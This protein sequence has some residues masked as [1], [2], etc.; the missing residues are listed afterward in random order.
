MFDF[1]VRSEAA[2]K[3]AVDQLPEIDVLNGDEAEVLAEMVEQCRIR[4]VELQW[5]S[6]YQDPPREAEITVRDRFANEVYRTRGTTVVVHVPFT[7]DAN[8][9]GVEPTAGNMRVAQATISGGEILVMWEG[10]LQDASQIKASLEEEMNQVRRQESWSKADCDGFNAQLEGKV[11]RWLADRRQHLE[12][13]RKIADVLDIPIGRRPSP[14][15]DLVS[16]P[17]RRPI[18][19]R[20]TGGGTAQAEQEL[21]I[22]DSDYDAVVEQI[23]SARAM[24]E[25]LPETFSPMGEEALR[26]VLLAILNNQFGPAVGELFSRKG[27]TD[28]AIVRGRGPI[29]IAECKNWEG[30]ATFQK[31]IKQL[32]GYLV[33]RDTKAALVLFVREKNVTAVTEK[34]LKELKG[35]PLLVGVGASIKDVPTVILHHEGDPRQHIRVALIIVPIPPVA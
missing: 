24:F 32:L 5:K 27:K 25:R 9:F 22:S 12:A 18:A 1:L 30:P 29:F 16:V 19:I 33:W 3:K 14:E 35:H 6:T 23:S 20:K 11:R 28:I 4:P 21:R 34:A 13:N 7:G 15:P 10:P 31:A 17:R 26:D 2:A 8:L